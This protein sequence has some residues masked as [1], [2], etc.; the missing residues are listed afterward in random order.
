MS[1]VARHSSRASSKAQFPQPRERWS[2]DSATKEGLSGGS[3][4]LNFPY[5]KPILSNRLRGLSLDSASVALKGLGY[6]LATRDNA[7]VA[8]AS[9]RNVL[10]RRSHPPRHMTMT[11]AS[12]SWRTSQS[13]VGVGASAL[14]VTSDGR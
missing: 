8:A 1:H 9:V 2:D 14:M 13:G 4:R 7:A 12:P 3:L 6:A 10:R 11:Q 5:S